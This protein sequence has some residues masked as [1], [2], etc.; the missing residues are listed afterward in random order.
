MY[1]FS[2]DGKNILCA[3]TCLM[4]NITLCEEVLHV[5]VYIHF[6]KPRLFTDAPLVHSLTLEH[7]YTSLV[8]MQ[9]LI[10]HRGLFDV[11]QEKLSQLA[12]CLGM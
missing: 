9:T 3:R 5:F 11:G 4:G 10:L 1:F 12:S 7:T 8:L 6:K 2:E